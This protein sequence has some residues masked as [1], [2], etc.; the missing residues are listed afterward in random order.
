[1]GL[2]TRLVRLEQH[3]A[4]ERV[5]GVQIDDGPVTAD[6]EEMTR[7]AFHERYPA[8]EIMHVVIVNTRATPRTEQVDA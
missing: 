8:D 7:E 6:G 1:M 3:G 5:W 2:K 4:P